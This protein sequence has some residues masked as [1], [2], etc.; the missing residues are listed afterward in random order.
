[1]LR[2]VSPR[3]RFLEHED[4]NSAA[5]K[6]PPVLDEGLWRYVMVLDILAAETRLER[7]VGKRQVLIA[8]NL[9]GPFCVV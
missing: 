4:S 8:V 1:M 5:E 6:D 3:E 2:T 9:L 7:F